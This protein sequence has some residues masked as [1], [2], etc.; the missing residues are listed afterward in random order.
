MLLTIKLLCYVRPV[1]KKQFMT[2]S[3]KNTTEQIKTINL[4]VFE[5]IPK[6]MARKV[7]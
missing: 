2:K 1:G 3:K 5:A 6:S 4:A 7:N